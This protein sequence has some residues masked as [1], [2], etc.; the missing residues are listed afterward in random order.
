MEPSKSRI[1]TVE[2]PE[3]GDEV[4]SDPYPVVEAHSSAAVQLAFST[5]DDVD[6]TRIFSLRA[7]VLKTVP[8]FFGGTFR[9]ALRMAMTK[10]CTQFCCVRR[11]VGSCSCYSQ[12]APPAPPPPPLPPHA[13]EP[14]P[15]VLMTRTGG[16]IRVGGDAVFAER[17]QDQRRRAL[18]GN[19]RHHYHSSPSGVGQRSVLTFVLHCGG[20][21]VASIHP[22]S[23]R[24]HHQDGKDDSTS[25]G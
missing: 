20:A 19:I 16:P 2:V 5:L 21:T 11:G 7:S 10:W 3:S 8:G 23:H 6:L 17:T 24:Q 15:Q 4:M 1:L 22:T 18:E 9:T 12:V 13:R 25:E 14:T